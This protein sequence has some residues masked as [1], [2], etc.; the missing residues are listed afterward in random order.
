RHPRPARGRRA[1]ARPLAELP[2]APARA[3][4]DRDAA[5]PLAPRGTR[6]GV[7][8]SGTRDATQEE[9]L[10]P[11]RV[12]E[13]AVELSLPDPEHRFDDVALGHE[14]GRPRRAPYRFDRGEWRLEF[15][16]PD[17]DRME[18]LL[19][20]DGAFAPDPANL[21]RTPGPFGEK[22]VIE[23]PEYRAPAWLATE[24]DYGPGEE[25]ELRCRRL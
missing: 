16:R 6:P 7:Q 15:P 25:L 8:D 19:G 9:A 5:E 24:A 14:L 12:R 10:T 23:W 18:Y 2:E 1:P 17:A 20:I 22:S 4:G 13:D 21:G 3:R 11:P